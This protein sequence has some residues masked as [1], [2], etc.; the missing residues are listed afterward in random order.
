MKRHENTKGNGVDWKIRDPE[1]HRLPS[2]CNVIP[3]PQSLHFYQKHKSISLDK[4]KTW[5]SSSDL[6]SCLVFTPSPKS[7][8]MITKTF[9]KIQLNQYFLTI[10]RESSFD[11]NLNIKGIR[12]MTSTPGALD[13]ET[14]H[15]RQVQLKSRKELSHQ[16]NYL[17]KISMRGH[18]KWLQLRLTL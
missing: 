5:M 16:P 9:L 10:H 18:D 6:F 8:Q 15:I 3:Y 17:E 11:L 12:Y 14:S 7:L 13:I 4:C 1:T 2:L